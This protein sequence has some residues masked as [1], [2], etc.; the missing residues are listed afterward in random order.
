MQVLKS[1]TPAESR[2]LENLDQAVTTA[3]LSW[4]TTHRGVTT[5]YRGERRLAWGQDTPNWNLQGATRP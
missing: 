4:E 3:A 2:G 1:V 5:P